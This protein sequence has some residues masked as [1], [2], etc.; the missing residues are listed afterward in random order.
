MPVCVAISAWLTPRRVSSEM[1]CFQSMR[2]IV[3]VANY[4]VN[5][6][7]ECGFKS[8]LDTSFVETIGSRIKALL[9]EQGKTQTALAD[10]MGVKPSHVSEFVRGVKDARKLSTDS[11]MLMC[12]ELST[13][14]EFLFYGH[15]EKMD[16]AQTSKEAELLMLFRIVPDD[17]KNM[18]LDILKAAGH[19]GN[20]V[21]A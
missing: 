14:P 5:R 1:S 7:S 10:A 19:S 17:K 15:G 18:L 11:F 13:T 8:L 20:D 3:A 6:Y 4:C 12:A 16:K 2:R 21:A 9:D